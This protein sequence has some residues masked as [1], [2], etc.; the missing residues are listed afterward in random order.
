[1]KVEP[2]PLLRDRGWRT[3]RQLTCCY[4]DDDPVETGA[5]LADALAARWRDDGP[6]PL[7]A[8]PFH[9]VVPFAWDR[10]LP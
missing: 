8:A 9:T 6:V 3:G 2:R 1:M 4:L 10:H 5:R 7:L